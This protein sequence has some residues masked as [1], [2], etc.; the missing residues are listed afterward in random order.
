MNTLIIAP[1]ADDELIGCY[2]V[3]KQ[4]KEHATTVLYLNELTDERVRETQLLANAMGFIP[5]Y[6]SMDR[7]VPGFYDTVYVPSIRDWHKDHKEANRMWRELATHF[8]S[9]DMQHGVYLGDTAAQAKH[10]LLD[11]FYPSQK[12]LWEGNAKYY[13]FEDIQERDFNVYRTYRL[14]W[15]FRIKCTTNDWEQHISQPDVQ[16]RL[17]GMQDG[18]TAYKLLLQVCQDKV[19]LFAGD[20]TYSID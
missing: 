13:L 10:V 5:Q 20:A 14:G 18:V 1:H 16:D 4:A 19:E 17:L 9:V 3:L 11:T 6:R 2:S 7:P 15:R 8:Y 12:Q